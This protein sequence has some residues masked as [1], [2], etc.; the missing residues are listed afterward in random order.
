MVSGRELFSIILKPRRRHVH[1]AESNPFSRLNQKPDANHTPDIS[2]HMKPDRLLIATTTVSSRELAD[3]IAQSL[4]DDRIAACVQ[5]EGPITSCYRWEGKVETATEWR[6]TI[7][8]IESV[9]ARLHEKVL[10]VH[11]YEVP[12]WIVV[13]ADSVSPD[14]GQWVQRSVQDASSP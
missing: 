1:L 4:I 9:A 6:L 5:I 12:Q 2:P 8:S 13:A 10:A 11:P 3:A 14:Y 7:K